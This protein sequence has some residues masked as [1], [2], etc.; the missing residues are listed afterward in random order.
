MRS[1]ARGGCP[2][3]LRP[4]AQADAENGP[5]R[6]PHGLQGAVLR[7]HR[8]AH[9]VPELHRAPHGHDRAG[10]GPC[11]S[12]CPGYQPRRRPGGEARRHRRLGGH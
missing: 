6:T 1:A 2:G 12:A 8:P 4:S 11:R 7:A 10:R 9:P 3:T 5:P